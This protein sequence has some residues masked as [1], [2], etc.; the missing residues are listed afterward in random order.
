MQIPICEVAKDVDLQTLVQRGDTGFDGSDEAVEM[1]KRDG[2]V[3]PFA[4]G[5]D[6]ADGQC[7]FAQPPDIG[8][9]LF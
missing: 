3:E 7:V 8:G 1:S 5:K 9:L 6:G 4:V 2:N